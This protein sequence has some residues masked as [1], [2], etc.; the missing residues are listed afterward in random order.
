[1]VRFSDQAEEVVFHQQHTLSKEVQEYCKENEDKDLS[2]V[3][4]LNSSSTVDLIKSSSLL[5][6]IRKA[7]TRCEI[8]TNGGTVHT[9]YEGM[10][11][12]YG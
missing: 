5:S 4:L 1:M 2:K 11:P 3:L 12:G 9:K 10:M 7:K 6:E 8:S